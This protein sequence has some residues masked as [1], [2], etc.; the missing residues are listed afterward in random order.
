MDG[1]FQES[2]TFD[3]VG[4]V[5]IDVGNSV[6]P[7]LLTEDAGELLLL[8]SVLDHPESIITLCCQGTEYQHKGLLIAL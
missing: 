6:F 7:Q 2:N 3:P 5:N 1:S 8:L 4:L